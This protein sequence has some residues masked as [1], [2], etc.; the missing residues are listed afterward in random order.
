VQVG[1]RRPLRTSGYVSSR[2]ATEECRSQKFSYLIWRRPVGV[3]GWQASMC[4][5]QTKI[6]D[7]PTIDTTDSI[8]GRGRAA[9]S[10]AP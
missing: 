2:W 7:P 5:D 10:T 3:Y 9:A 6:R 1:Q 8:A 4:S